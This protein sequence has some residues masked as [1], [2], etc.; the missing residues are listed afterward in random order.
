MERSLAYIP[1]RADSAGT[2]ALRQAGITVAARY[3]RTEMQNIRSTWDKW[4]FGTSLRSGWMTDQPTRT[5]RK[6][7]ASKKAT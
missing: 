5:G 1:L 7:E 4:T 3:G 6:S 2:L